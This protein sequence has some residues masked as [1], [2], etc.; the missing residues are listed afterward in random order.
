MAKRTPE[1]DERDQLI[2]Q[3]W[4][5]DP[6]ATLE[7]I[8]KDHRLTR[9]SI[10]QILKKGLGEDRAKFAAQRAEFRTEDRRRR[11]RVARYGDRQCRVCNSLLRDGENP[12]RN[13]CSTDCSTAWSSWAI[14]RYLDPDLYDRHRAMLGMN[15][16]KPPNRRFMVMGGQAAELLKR[17]RPDI[18]EQFVE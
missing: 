2:C 18:Y 16:S 9:E 12:K 1:L 11:A 5:D 17:V 15:L 3:Q 13:T 10:R 7:S 6:F 4:L 14:R 8:G